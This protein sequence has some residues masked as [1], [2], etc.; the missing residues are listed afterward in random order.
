MIQSQ[1]G[2]QKTRSE[3]RVREA[4]GRVCASKSVKCYE[5]E[6]KGDFKGAGGLRRI[7]T[8]KRDKS[9]GV[10]TEAGDSRQ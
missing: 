4:T 8:E 2:R 3:K 10:G 7:S 5:V 6:E 9:A 1:K